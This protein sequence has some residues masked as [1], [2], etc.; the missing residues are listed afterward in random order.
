MVRWPGRATVLT[1]DAC[2]VQVGIIQ[3]WHML[4]VQM[5]PILARLV[6]SQTMSAAAAQAELRKLTIRY[7]ITEQ[8]ASWA[9]SVN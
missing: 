9:F 7:T 3:H 6:A 5:T 2:D 8:L 4:L 1:A